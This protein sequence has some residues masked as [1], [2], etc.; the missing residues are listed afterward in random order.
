MS[1]TLY[2]K[3]LA[4][5]R[6]IGQLEEIM[7]LLSWDQE[8]MMP[9]GALEGRAQQK[10][11]LAGIAHD[12]FTSPM[13]GEMARE[14]AEDPAIK[15]NPVASANLREF[16]R[17]YDRSVKVPTDLVQ[18]LQRTETEAHAAWIEARAQNRFEQFAPHLETLLQLRREEAQAIDDRRHPYNVQLEKFEVGVD[19]ETIAVLFEALKKGLLPLLDRIKGAS[20]RPNAK[21]LAGRFEQGKQEIFLRSVIEAIGF[22][23]KRG[24]LDVS[25]HPFCGGAGMSDIR[26]TT[27]FTDE[28]FHT[29]LAGAIHETGHAL[30]E[31]GLDPAHRHEPVASARSMGVHESQSLLWEKHVG[32]SREFWNFYFPKAQALFAP[33]LANTSLDDFYFALNEVTPSLIRVDADEV[34]YPLHVI[35]RFELEKN[36][37]TGEMKV[38]DLPQAWNAGMKKYLGLTPPTNREGV[39]QDVHWSMGLFG[40]FPTYNLGAIYASQMFRAAEK[41]LPGLRADFAKGDF[42]RLKSWLNTQ[43]HRRGSLLETHELI[44]TVC[45]EN[46]NVGAHLQRLTDK[47]GGLYRL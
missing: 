13:L 47:Y 44:K 26:M 45:G 31:Q 32:L 43:V 7:G 42:S 28:D 25:V 19:F 11:T 46:I 17:A 5:L 24:R 3:F 27:R 18:R 14:L 12:R 4:Q 33:A 34:T 37:M 36:L 41:A 15:S 35:L 1:Q 8:T 39:L 6:D 10:A 21:V 30:Y 40:Y 16:R 20:H 29:S 22:D 2:Q 23:F 38:E 9:E